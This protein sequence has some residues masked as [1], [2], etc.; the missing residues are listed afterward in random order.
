MSAVAAIRASKPKKQRARTSPAQ[1]KVIALPA[2]VIA[3]PASAALAP[4]L[5]DCG[6]PQ[7]RRCEC[8]PR[9]RIFDPMGRVLLSPVYY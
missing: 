8:A 9:L 1:A 7:G 6:C 3:L 2:N 4:P 5:R